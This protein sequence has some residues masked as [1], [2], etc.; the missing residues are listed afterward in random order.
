[1]NLP[2]LLRGINLASLILLFSITVFSQSFPVEGTI[3]GADGQPLAG[4]TIQ[5]KGTN[6][7]TTTKADGTFQIN[8]PSSTSVLALTYVGFTQQE[9]SVNNQSRL[10]VSMTP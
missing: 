1:M 10:T 8:A 5:V 9:V 7:S 2:G 6:I 3:T 4:V